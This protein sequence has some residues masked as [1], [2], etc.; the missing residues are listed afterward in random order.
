MTVRHPW[1]RTVGKGIVHLV[2]GFILDPI[3]KRI[4]PHV[5]ELVEEALDEAGVP[6]ADRAR[7]RTE[8]FG[9]AH[10]DGGES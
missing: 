5:P 1:A 8:V 7:V 4:C 9:I 3:L 2:P 10:R 6:D